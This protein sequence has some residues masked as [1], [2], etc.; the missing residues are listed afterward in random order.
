MA[1]PVIFKSLE[2]VPMA[3]PV[4][5]KQDPHGVLFSTMKENLIV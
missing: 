3:T 2:V 5:F 1:T 4:I